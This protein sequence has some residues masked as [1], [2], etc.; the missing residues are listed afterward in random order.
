MRFIGYVTSLCLP[1][2]PNQATGRQAYRQSW[3]P[4]CSNAAA[5]VL[6][7]SRE[8]NANTINKYDSKNFPSGWPSPA[9][10]QPSLFWRNR[11]LLRSRSPAEQT[12]TP[13]QKTAPSKPIASGWSYTNGVWTHV[14]GYKLV[15]GQVV[16]SGVQTHKKAPPPPTK[17]EMDAVMNKKSA[18]KTAGGKRGREGCGT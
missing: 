8:R 9:L 14:N 18:P 15:N 5:R 12:P 1:P 6:R 4:G 11:P 16:R 10:A 7:F 13:A 3:F 2:S 17:A